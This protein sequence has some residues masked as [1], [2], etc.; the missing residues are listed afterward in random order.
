MTRQQQ[1]VVKA[2]VLAILVVFAI[3]SVSCGGGGTKT[4]PIPSRAGASPPTLSLSPINLSFGDQPAETSSN[5]A[6]V[7]LTNTGTTALRIT[8]IALTGSNASSFVHSTDCG[9]SVEAGGKCTF[10]I[11]FAPTVSG[12][13]TATLTLTDNASGSPQSIGL[14]GKGTHDVILSWRPSATPGIAGYNIYRSTTS[15]AGSNPLN[16]SPLTG[17]SYADTKV[18]AGQE[19]WYW[20]TTIGLDGTM[21]SPSSPGVSVTIPSP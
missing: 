9:D 13:Q 18:Q 21:Q 19:Y 15:K 17:T 10:V 11:M 12:T 20:V 16:T 3:F 5:P 7:T 6:S 4:I 8:S 2:T 14:S 1:F